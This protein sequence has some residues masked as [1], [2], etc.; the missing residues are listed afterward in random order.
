M[1]DTNSIYKIKFCF[2]LFCP[3]M[4]Y[5]DINQYWRIR[6]HYTGL[7]LLMKSLS[8]QVSEIYFPSF[9]YFIPYPFLT[10]CATLP[11]SLRPI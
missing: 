7:G 4:V 1:N 5:N 9:P 11:T 10:C 6:K 8:S 2:D 3:F